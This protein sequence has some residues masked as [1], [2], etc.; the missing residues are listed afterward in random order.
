MTETTPSGS[1]PLLQH[2]AKLPTYLHVSTPQS[3]M[4]AKPFANIWNGSSLNGHVHFHVCVVDGVFEEVAGQ[5]NA[6]TDAQSS[7][8]GI[9]F[10]RASAID[11]AA[12][13][14]VQTDLRRRILRAFIGRGLLESLEAKEMLGYQHSGFPVDANVCIQATPEPTPA[15]RSPAHYLWAVLIARTCEVLPVA[16]PAVWWTDAPDRLHYR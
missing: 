3:L 13:A 4:S 15:K 2:L 10:H 5:G 6:G 12:V 8:P 1:R 9:V 14:Q 7:P 16:V 11:E